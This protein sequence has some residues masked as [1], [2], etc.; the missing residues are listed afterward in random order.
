MAD[1]FPTQNGVKQ[2]DDSSQIFFNFPLECAVR[3]VQEYQ[4]GL[5]L[6]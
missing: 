6:N 5:E 1:I 4:E 2:R 3:K